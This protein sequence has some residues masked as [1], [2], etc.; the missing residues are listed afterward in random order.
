M[1]KSRILILGGAGQDGLLLQELLTEFDVEVFATRRPSSITHP[2]FEDCGSKWIDINLQDQMALEKVLLDVKP[3]K[4][5]HLAA[6]HG[7]SGTEFETKFREIVGVNLA[8]FQTCLEYCRQHD[9]M[10][11][12]FYASSTRVFGHQSGQIC[13]DSELLGNDLYAISKKSA[14]EVAE[15]Y[16]QNHAIKILTAYM[17]QHESEYRPDG[18]FMTLVF[19]HLHQA[20]NDLNY[21]GDIRSLSNYVD[22]NCAR[23]FMRYAWDIGTFRHSENVIFSSNTTVKLKQLVADMFSHFGL[24]SAEFIRETVQTRHR[25]ITNFNYDN[26][27]LKRIIGYCDQR[28]T[29]DVMLDIFKR[30]QQRLVEMNTDA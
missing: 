8:S 24:N 6:V 14:G 25:E 21:V 11:W 5:F 27:R 7:S 4:I 18:F 16:R 26:S 19:D 29:C 9:P 28:A 12:V 17:A 13:E 15:Y 30:K 23:M 10:C 2:L 20:L 3:D 22:Y 1:K